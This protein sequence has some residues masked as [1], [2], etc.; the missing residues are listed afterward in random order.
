[1]VAGYLLPRVSDLTFAARMPRFSEEF[2]AS[3]DSVDSLNFDSFAPP[4][5]FDMCK[6]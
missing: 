4:W 5:F 1:M 2:S 6:G 3:R